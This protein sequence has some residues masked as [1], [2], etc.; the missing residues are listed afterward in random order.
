M[1]VGAAGL[2]NGCNAGW[3]PSEQNLFLLGVA[4]CCR[5]ALSLVL[6][7]VQAL[8]RDG[9]QAQLRLVGVAHQQVLACG[10]AG[11]GQA[12][13]EGQCEWQA[14]AGLMVVH[15]GVRMGVSQCFDRAGERQKKAGG[16][17][18]GE[19][20]RRNK[21]GWGVCASRAHRTARPL[22]SHAAAAEGAPSWLGG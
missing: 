3:L 13:K 19:Q 7:V 5:R 9:V 14:G 8:C 20:G 17:R 18:T 11:A 21:G 6:R 4:V 1:R 16:S 22:G 10:G 12:G 15:A 2:R